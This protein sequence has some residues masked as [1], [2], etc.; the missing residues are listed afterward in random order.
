MK[1]FHI[2]SSIF[3]GF[4]ELKFNEA[5]VF[6]GIN[7]SESDIN[8]EQQM[9]FMRKIPANVHALGIF[10]KYADTITI[11]EV[12]QELTFDMFWKRYDDKI[13]SSK[14]KTLAKW[15]KMSA[16]EQAK[17]YRH[18]HKYFSSIPSGTRKKYA[19]TYLNAE[20]WNN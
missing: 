9:W 10:T 11:T 4:I 15:N 7:F 13:S 5:E 8:I 3:N 1:I 18:I 12:V 20:L 2:T 14:K 16:A 19:E 6:T 17:A